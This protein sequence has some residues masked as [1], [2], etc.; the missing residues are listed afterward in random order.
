MDVLVT[1][2]TKQIATD[3]TNTMLG[4]MHGEYTYR[5]FFSSFLP[6]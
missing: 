2:T 5:D 1:T 6:F 3:D 4:Q